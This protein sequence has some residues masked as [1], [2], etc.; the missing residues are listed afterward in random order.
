MV[1]PKDSE[2]GRGLDHLMEQNEAELGFLSAY[3]GVDS[4]KGEDGSAILE[5]LLRFMRAGGIE[6]EQKAGKVVFEFGS[7]TAE[8]DGCLVLCKG[9]HLPL[10]ASDLHA[11]GFHDGIIGT[12][13]EKVSVRFTLWNQDHRRF[14]E[15]LVE[16]HRS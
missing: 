1:V 5:A 9:K 15:R 16:H 4:P 11:P 8:S 12:K 3:G 7:A 6:C 13:R 2:D 14:L 10:V